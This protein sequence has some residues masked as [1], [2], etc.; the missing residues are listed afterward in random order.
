[1]IWHKVRKTIIGLK[2]NQ[3]NRRLLEAQV[4]AFGIEKYRFPQLG[5]Y[6]DFLF[7]FINYFFN[8]NRFI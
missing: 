3:E 8:K 5:K 7:Y 4:K 2:Y 1:L 6:I